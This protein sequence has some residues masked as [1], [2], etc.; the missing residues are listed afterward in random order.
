[1]SESNLISFQNY[2]S[3]ASFLTSADLYFSFELGPEQTGDPS[4]VASAMRLFAGTKCV[5][6]SAFTASLKAAVA[7]AMGNLEH[8]D[9]LTLCAEGRLRAVPSKSGDRFQVNLE[10]AEAPEVV[11][12][13]SGTVTID[14]SAFSLG[15]QKS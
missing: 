11:G 2:E 6:D 14:V 10:Y 15:L 7:T 8:M 3:F 1:M 13:S 12:S 4:E 9:G 5:V